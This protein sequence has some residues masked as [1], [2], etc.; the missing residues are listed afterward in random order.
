LFGFQGTPKKTFHAF[1]LFR[2]L[3]G[4]P[5]RVRVVRDGAVAAGKELVLAAGLDAT[6]GSGAVL[7]VHEGPEAKRL[8]L[9]LAGFPG[10]GTLQARV[11][12]L[13]A[14]RDRWREVAGVPED[15]GVGRLSVS[16]P[17]PAVVLIELERR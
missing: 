7:A 12:L 14:A 11:V 4:A 9:G 10:K 6:G 13:D 3:L 5:R 15:T 8:D 1:H 2:E 16:L 17:G